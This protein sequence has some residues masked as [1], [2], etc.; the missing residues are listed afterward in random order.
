ME[1]STWQVMRRHP[2][3]EFDLGDPRALD[4]TPRP[5]GFERAAMLAREL[6]SLHSLG[7]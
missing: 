4:H 2:A 5:S 1:A 3:P 6:E 7:V